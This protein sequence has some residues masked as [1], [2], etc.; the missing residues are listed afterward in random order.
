MKSSG[1]R[2]IKIV[3]RIL[4]PELGESPENSLY[5][6]KAAWQYDKYG[7]EI[8]DAAEHALT[9]KMQYV[10]GISAAELSGCLHQILRKYNAH[11][12]LLLNVNLGGSF[13]WK[14]KGEKD[15]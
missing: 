11:D 1:N 6:D 4:N 9:V 5:K 3:F 8:S 15:E 13:Y 10:L 7:Q 2:S 14:L 12:I